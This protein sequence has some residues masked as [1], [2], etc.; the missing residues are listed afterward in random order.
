MMDE[1]AFENLAREIMTQGYDEATAY[2]FAS[3]IGDT[4]IADEVGNILV[5]DRRGRQ[6]SKLKP[7]RI[8]QG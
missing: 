8:F 1:I 4:P 5:Y 2:R 7:L 6:I 3:L